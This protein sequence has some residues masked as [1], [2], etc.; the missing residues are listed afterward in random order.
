MFVRDQMTREILT[1]SRIVPHSRVARRRWRNARVT[2]GPPGRAQR[3]LGRGRHFFGTVSD[4]PNPVGTDRCL[5]AEEISC[6]DGPS[7]L[8]RHGRCIGLSVE[9]TEV[10]GI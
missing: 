9:I 8:G 6:A 5:A 4:A 7:L 10:A 2:S 3:N 1:G